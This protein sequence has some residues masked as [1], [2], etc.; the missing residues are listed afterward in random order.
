MKISRS[1]ARAL[2]LDVAP[3]RAKGRQ[4]KPELFLAACSAHRIPAP[5]PEHEFHPTRKWRFDWAWPSEM[6][7]LEI[8]GGAWTGGRHTRGQGFVDDQ[9]KRNEAVLL[10]W[11]V[12]HCVPADVQSGKVFEM[13]R[14]V[15]K[16]Y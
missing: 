13:L 14:R 12:L 16:G 7:A 3:A 8:D 6:V 4:N 1:Q 15:F 9:E 10:G 5:V 2:G 11:R